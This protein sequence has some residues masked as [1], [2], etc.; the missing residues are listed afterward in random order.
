MHDLDRGVRIADALSRAKTAY[1]AA[2]SVAAADAVSW[3]L[4]RAGRCS[5][6]RGWTRTAGRLGTK[7]ALFAFHRGMIERCLGAS[8]SARASFQEALSIDPNFSLR[9]TDLARMYAS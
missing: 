8:D 4:Y 2:P 3:G 6:A 1:A 7:D 5:E 9:W